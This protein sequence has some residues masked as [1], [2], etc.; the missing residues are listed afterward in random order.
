[1]FASPSSDHTAYPYTYDGPLVVMDNVH[2]TLGGRKILEGINLKIDNI[3]RPGLSQG[4]IEVIL[5]PS[6]VGKSQTFWLLAG[7]NQPTS[8]TVHIGNPGQPVKAG[9]VGVVTQHYKVFNHRT[10]MENLLIAGTRAGL[11]EKDA[12]DKAKAYL[13]RFGIPEKRDGY[14]I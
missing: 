12:L 6:G 7:I 8:G 9:M 4:Q 10:V 3:V 14:P 13:E 2:L 5:G 11:S 1:M